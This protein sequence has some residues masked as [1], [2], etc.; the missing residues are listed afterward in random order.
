MSA[1]PNI[2]C[3]WF[4]PSGWT[5][6]SLSLRTR[7]DQFPARLDERTLKDK[8]PKIVE[9]VRTCCPSGAGVPELGAAIANA[10]C[11]LEDITFRTSVSLVKLKRTLEGMTDPQAAHIRDTMSLG[12]YGTL[13]DQCGVDPGQREAFLRRL[14]DLGVMLYFGDDPRLELNVVLNPYWVTDGIYRIINYEPLAQA[15]GK[16]KVEQIRAILPKE[17]YPADKAMYIL[18]MM[19]KFE[20]CFPLD[21]Q[22][23]LFLLPDLLPPQ[24]P[25]LP[26][27]D[28]DAALKLQFEYPVWQGAALT[29][30]LVRLNHY[31]VEK[32]YWRNG[33]LLQSPDRKNRG[34]VIADEADRRLRIWVDGE[35]STRR[36]LLNR[37]REELDVIHGS[38]RDLIV[39][40]WVVT[41]QGGE[42]EYQLL[43]ELEAQGTDKYP[44]LIGGK[45]VQLDVKELL[46]GV[47]AEVMPDPYRLE[48]LIVG[49]FTLDE[50]D[51]LCFKFKMSL[52]DIEGENTLPSKARNLIRKFQRTSRMPEFMAALREM[53]PNITWA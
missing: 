39:K 16:L 21:E 15:G 31:L 9:F 1:G 49:H 34:L 13:C 37:I 17:R 41:L 47:R 4:A 14:N 3:S 8:Y 27:F 36:S 44:I 51:G 50:L 2:G 25:E 22:Q 30:L 33:A 6:L 19:R 53:Y 38:Q 52:E 43:A 32:A 35:P 42:V 28:R 7:L 20:L 46:S 5:R 29:R 40:A 12:E 26:P 45:L 10:V 24:Q 23:T 11:K 48:Q 18:D